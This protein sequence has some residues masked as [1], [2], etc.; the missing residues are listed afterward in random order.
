MVR[1]LLTFSGYLGS[2]LLLLG[3]T[4]ALVAY[5][6]DYSYDFSTRQVIQKGHVIIA[7]NPSGVKVLADGKELKNKRT[8]YQAAYKVG[9][10]TFELLKDGYWPWKKTFEVVAG[11]VSLARYVVMV[12]KNPSNTILDTRPQIVA[13]A[14]SKDHRRIAYITGGT[15]AALYTVDVGSTKPTK[16]YTPKAASETE[17]LEILREITWSDDASHLLV[18]SARGEQTIYRLAAVSGG[19]PT[20]LTEQYKVN[21]AGLRFSASNWRQL[22]WNSP[23]GLRRLDVDAQAMSSVLV[24]KV[25]QFWVEPDRVLYVQQTD[26]GRSLW[27]L[28]NRGKHQELIAALVESD[29][30]SVTYTNYRGQDYLAVVPAKTQVGTLYAGIFGNTPVAKILAHGVTSA[31]F[32]PDG[33]LLAF[34]SPRTIV[35][36]D[37]QRSS[38]AGDSIIYNITDQPGQLSALT[39]FDNYHLLT[40]REGVVYWSEFDGANLVA[41]GMTVAG[42]PAYG[43]AD[44]KSVVSFRPDGQLVRITQSQIK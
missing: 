4:F 24:S 32:S 7:S 43:S 25:S 16:L 39:W 30:Y 40:S 15:D 5:G 26:L 37:I 10:H 14:M 20:N 19:E 27:S 44:F 11:Q 34:S 22:Y 42:F 18:V 35:T 28:D 33:H 6:K 31:A 17:S 8:P 23:E 36:Y 29:S 12:P 38:I 1:R 9:Q 21:L 41:L 13:Q 2:A 3:V